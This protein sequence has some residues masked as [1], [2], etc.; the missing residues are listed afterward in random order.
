LIAHRKKRNH[1]SSFWNDFAVAE[2]R[3]VGNLGFFG[4]NGKFLKHNARLGKALM[5]S[6][7]APGKV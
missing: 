2:E 3:I 7:R 5:D 1:P 6:A 4:S